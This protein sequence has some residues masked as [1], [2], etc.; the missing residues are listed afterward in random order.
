MTESSPTITDRID[1][2]DTTEPVAHCNTR[3]YQVLAWVGITA[4]IVF[5]VG[6]VFFSGFFAA[7]VAGGDG[8]H[9]GYE[10]GQM[11]TDGPRGTGCPMMQMQPGGM[12]PGG[13]GSGGMAPGGA[14]GSATTSV[15]PMPPMPPGG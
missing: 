11:G 1:P 15:R 3:L 8:W 10:R 12:G 2:T 4:G 6:A 5:I 7:R 13:M 9:R 14:T